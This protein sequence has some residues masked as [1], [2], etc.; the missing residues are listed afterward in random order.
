MTVSWSTKYGRRR[1]RHEPPTLEEAL[2]AAEGLSFDPVEQIEIAAELM[3]VPVEEVRVEATRVLK[4]RSRRHQITLSPGRRTTGATV[5]VEKKA[6]RR[7]IIDPRRSSS[8]A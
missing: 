1:V 4:E 7:I 6:P 2:Y 5:V 8:A 3:A